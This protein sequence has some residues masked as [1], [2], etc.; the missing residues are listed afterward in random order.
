MAKVYRYAKAAP[1][2]QAVIF[3][4]VST[5][6]QE[7]GA[8]L[9]AQKAAMEDYCVKKGL[10]IVNKYRVIE[11]S[12]NGKRVVFHEML[13]FVRKQKNKTA[14]VVHCIDRFQ[15]R[16]NECVE[17]ETLL[18]DDKIDI[19]FCKEGL[20]LT[21]NSSSADIMRW[22]MGILSGKM[23]V[24]NLRDNVNRGME[25]KWSNGEYQTKSPVGYLNIPKT[26][27]TPANIILDPERAPLVKKMFEMYATGCYSIKSLQQFA[28]E[29]NLCSVRSKNHKPL[30]RETIWNTLKNPF[31]YGEMKIRGEIMPHKYEP[32]ISKAL[33]EQVQEV[34]SGKNAS[35][36]TREYGGISFAFRK[37]IK[38]AEC[39]GTIS[40]E[41]H[42]KKSGRKYT[43]LRCT[44]PK[45]C[46]HQGL[47]SELQL[48]KQLDDE[49][50]SKI[51]LNAN[52]I[53]LLKKCVQKKMME[54]SEANAVMKRQ[55]T[56][57]L[58]QL[59]AREQR[60]KDCFFN[61][62]ITR[63]EWNEEKNNIASKREE[64]QHTA[65][66]YEDISRDIQYTVNEVLDIV[67][68]ASEIMKKAN[69]EQQ[70]NLL[71]LIL[72]ECYLDG[73]RLIYKLKKPFDMLVN[74]KNSDNWFEFDKS[75]V[76]EYDRLANQVQMYKIKA[77]MNAAE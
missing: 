36:P 12:T 40:S 16:F 18:L 7:P 22:D 75:D 60:V 37:L 15:R 4:R 24:A 72:D 62:D 51:R 65:E 27:T 74:L 66:K 21:K 38:C 70:N 58:N 76:Q 69:P 29:M 42:F 33:F 56:N 55:I 41:Q 31:Y 59:E 34:L 35:M 6:E 2:T 73:E 9:D 25:Y 54:D 20:I 28:K 30:G 44:H 52:I 19:H 5:K 64:L 26:K 32:I 1:C 13:D 47:V 11:S 71:G 43:Y 61:G 46:C 53:D 23:Y 3:A 17:V 50:F 49:V 77:E 8:S 45:G 39:G 68:C 57:E 67:A 63:D 48:L 10:K 14:I